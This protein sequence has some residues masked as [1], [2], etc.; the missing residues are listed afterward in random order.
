MKK[1]EEPVGKGYIYDSNCATF[2]KRQHY[3]DNKNDQW[4]PKVE[5]AEALGDEQVEH[6]GC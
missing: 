2:W 1:V 3:R 5:A 6:R 4:L